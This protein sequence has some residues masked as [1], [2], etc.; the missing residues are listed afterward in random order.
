MKFIYQ[1]DLVKNKCDATHLKDDITFS[2]FLELLFL[3]QSGY[4]KRC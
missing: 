1:F 3:L 4:Y 2:F